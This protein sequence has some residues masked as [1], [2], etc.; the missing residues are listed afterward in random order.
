MAPCPVLCP[1]ATIEALSIA[2]LNVLFPNPDIPRS[3]TNNNVTDWFWPT[4]TTPPKLVNVTEPVE[5]KVW[6]PI[7]SVAVPEL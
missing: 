3:Y 5:L 7:S 6:L 2:L 1:S 4:V